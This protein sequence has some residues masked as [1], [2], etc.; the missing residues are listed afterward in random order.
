MSVGLLLVTHGR[1]GQDLLDTATT[2]LGS[3][4]LPQKVIGVRLDQ[5][6][7][8]LLD[9]IRAAGD[10]LNEG[11]GVLVLTDMY[12]STPSNLANRL[13]TRDSVRVVA[14]LSLPMLVR[15]L[16]YADLSLDELAT[17]AVSGG[18]EGVLL[19]AAGRGH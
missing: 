16:N 19:C 17:K 15:V 6:I 4:P 11:Q 5:D 8:D 2:L 1:I 12:G 13:D 14:G 7:D 10:E 18:R 9:R 3:C